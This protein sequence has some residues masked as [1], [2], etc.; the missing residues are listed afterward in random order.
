MSRQDFVLEPG[1]PPDRWV[2]WGSTAAVGCGLVLAAGGAL[3]GDVAALVA[4]A[5]LACVGMTA[6]L[7]GGWIDGLLLLVLVLLAPAPYA[8]EELRISAAAVV[9]ALVVFA[10]MARRGVDSSPIRLGTLPRRAVAGVLGAVGL[11]A[12][13]A[14]HPLPALRELASFALLLGLLV[15][16]TD[17]LLK[18]PARSRGLVLAVAG[19]VAV[20]GPLAALEAIGVLPGRFPLEGTSLN[21]ATL[22]LGWPNELGMFFALGLPMTVYALQVA[23][24][25]WGRALAG[26][27]VASATVGLVATFS[28]GAWIAVPAATLILFVAGEGRFA[29]RVL[30]VAFVAALVVDLASGGIV[31]ERLLGLPQDWVVEQRAA[32]LVV[33]LLMFREYPVLG[34]GP[35]GFAGELERFGPQ[36]PWLWDYV[37]DAHNAYIQMAA[38]TG[39]LG[40]AAFLAFV[41]TTLLVLL[42][43]TR[44]ARGCPA[45]P[46]EERA[47]RRTILWGFAV[48]CA[49]S[50]TAW[51]FAHGV[52]QL[53]VLVAA[54]GFALPVL[55]DV[56]GPASERTG[57]L[58]HR[59][60]GGPG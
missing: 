19:V 53:V 54:V 36:I 38:E 56:P 17:G 40:L 12:A 47:L 4:G 60:P 46:R 39:L 45:T 35:G 22:G 34:V 41:G 44:E 59:D 18:S 50:L 8:G 2:A 32:L 23:P 24:R 1:A 20:A 21:R 15:A 49:V 51:P 29:L 28:R 55:G 14:L 48:A 10:W 3:A 37:G 9:T 58:A 52:G 27:A 7:V 25:G 30:G 57:A 11:S 5:A 31:R 43:R 13:F 26:C 42:R 33:G 6:L 16:A